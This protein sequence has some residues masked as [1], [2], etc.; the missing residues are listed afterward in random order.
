[1]ISTGVYVCSISN[2]CLCIY[3]LIYLETPGLGKNDQVTDSMFCTVAMWG[4][5]H[6]SSLLLYFFIPEKKSKNKIKMTCTKLVF[7]CVLF[8]IT[9]D[10]ISVG[11]LENQ[12]SIYALFP[13]L[14]P[15]SL[16][17]PLLRIPK[18]SIL[19]QRQDAPRTS[20]LGKK[21]FNDF[22]K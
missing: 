3:T 20:V 18:S 13:P 11:L 14:S 1:M 4:L 19:E 6:C 22:L 17:H 7:V 2:K 16:R 15:P 12:F 21:K 10:N 9:S 5:R 8:Y